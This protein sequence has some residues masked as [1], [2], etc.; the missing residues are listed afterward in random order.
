MYDYSMPL[1]V[2]S[3]DMHAYILENCSIGIQNHPIYMGRYAQ[4]GI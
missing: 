1:M 4:E 2:A 3:N